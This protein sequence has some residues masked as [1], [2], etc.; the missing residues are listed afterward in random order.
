MSLYSFVLA[1]RARAPHIM[2]MTLASL[3]DLYRTHVRAST[4]TGALLRRFALQHPTEVQEPADDAAPDRDV[5]DE[6]E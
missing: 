5:E 6:A 2:S 4:T 3:R 1:L